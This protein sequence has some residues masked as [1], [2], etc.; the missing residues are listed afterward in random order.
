MESIPASTDAIV[1][2]G[3]PEIPQEL[4]ELQ[5]RPFEKGDAHEVKE[6]CLNT[7]MQR[8][9]LSNSYVY[10]SPIWLAVYL[11]GIAWASN[12]FEPWKYHDWG[13]WAFLC[14]AISALCLV[15]VDYFTYQYYESATRES[16][17]NDVFLQDPEKY[18]RNGSAKAWVAI[19]NNIL[20]GTV[21][22]RPCDSNATAEISHWYVRA[23]YRN[24]GLGSDLLH[25]AIAAAQQQKKTKNIKC[26]TSTITARA[27]KSLKSLG[28]KRA[29][30]KSNSNIYWRALRIK[31]YVWE[32]DLSSYVKSQS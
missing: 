8:T 6:F 25:E 10:R 23:R 22:L 24:K 14:C 13:R 20:A 31:D 28:F 30:A 12:K 5:I 29:S 19:Y 17:K 15:S 16:A 26:A 7:M 9:R 11:S 32:L 27:N 18:L 2:A 3:S 4:P 21:L 1:P